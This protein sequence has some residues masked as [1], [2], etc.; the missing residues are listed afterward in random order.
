MGECY[1]HTV[2]VTGSNPVPPTSKFK[3]LV[4]SIL[5]KPFFYLMKK[6][7]RYFIFR[8]LTTFML[9]VIDFSFFCR[10]QRNERSNVLQMNINFQDLPSISK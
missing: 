3:G 1:L 5:T 9:E 8:G 4:S 6:K 7:N 2:E 10:E